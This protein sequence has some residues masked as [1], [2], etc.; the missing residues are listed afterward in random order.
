[1]AAAPPG[2]ME[3]PRTGTISASRFE[4]DAMDSWFL[5]AVPAGLALIVVGYSFWIAYA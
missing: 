5:P 4:G 1:M 2:G 3:H